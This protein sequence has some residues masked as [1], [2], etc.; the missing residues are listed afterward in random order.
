MKKLFFICLMLALNLGLVAWT[1]AQGPRSDL[2]D[3]KKVEQE[4]E[5]MK[6]ILATTL[7]FATRELLGGEKGDHS[8]HAEFIGQWGI[9][10]VSAFYLYGQG[11]TFMI[12]TSSL[13]LSRRGGETLIAAYELAEPLVLHEDAMKDYQQALESA[14]ELQRDLAEERAEVAALKA[15]AAAPAPRPEPKVKTKQSPEEIR[16]KIAEAQEKVKKR[17][18]EAEQ[19]HQKF[20]EVLAQVK[21]HLVEALAN[22]GD[23][24]TFVKPNEY[25]N[26]VLSTDEGAFLLGG[27][28]RGSNREI[29]SIQK[30]VVSDY[31]AGRVTLE[32]L[33]QKVLQYSN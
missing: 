4:M 15:Q 26:L 25:I 13:R 21:V 29:I 10:G 5:I 14:A 20:M 23:S 33:R 31:K 1:L 11:A 32:G 22:H 28:R 24:L 19:R 27:Q 6:G 2:F 12:P 30:S 18:E 7:D 3:Q 8:P 9:S 16:K 17:R